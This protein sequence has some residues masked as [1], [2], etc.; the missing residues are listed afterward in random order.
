[1]ICFSEAG[2]PRLGWKGY[3]TWGFPQPVA[4]EF[5][6]HSDFPG[7]EALKGLAPGSREFDAAWRKAGSQGPELFREAQRSFAQQHYYDP[8]VKILKSKCGLDVGTRSYTLQEAVW[9]LAVRTGPTVPPIV[10]ACKELQ[11]NQD[12]WE[13]I[14]SG[15]DEAIIRQSFSGLISR[16]LASHSELAMVLHQLANEQ[17]HS[18]D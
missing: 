8:A 7:H 15:Y 17:H 9:A 4:A 13:H 14:D 6:A 2:V 12:N 10:Q 16:H 5:V 18:K 3:G 11:N 1:V